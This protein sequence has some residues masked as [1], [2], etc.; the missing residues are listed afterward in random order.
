MKGR[1]SAKFIRPTHVDVELVTVAYHQ[2]AFPMHVHEQYVVGVVEAGA[3]MLEVD[4]ASHVITAGGMITVD[5]GQPHSN[6]T[7][8]ND[9]LRYRVFYLSSCLV[10]SHLDQD[11][12][13][14]RAPSRPA[15]AETQRLLTLHR[16]FEYNTGDSLAQ[17]SAIAEVVDIAFHVDTTMSHEPRLPKI[18]RLARE[19]IDQ[20][21][22]EGFGLDELALAIGASKFHATRCFTRA[23]G[24]SPIAYRTQRR[25]HEAKRLILAGMPLAEV[26]TD[27][28]F[29]DQSHLTRHFQSLV[30]IAPG[31]YREQ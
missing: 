1:S 14:F 29:A 23:Y 19:Y 13:R 25:I 20:N 24:L 10:A 22:R 31:Q 5:P 17:Q 21:F 2:R 9:C 3:E 11:P 30:G 27:L 8:G 28:S 16:W 26:A 18:A 12:M 6:R 4:G 7:L 15:S